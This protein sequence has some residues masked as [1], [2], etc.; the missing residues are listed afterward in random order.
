[1]KTTIFNVMV[2][3]RFVF[4]LVGFLM[5]SY[6]LLSACSASVENTPESVAAFAIKTYQKGNFGDLK[7]YATE[8]LQKQ[9]E[10]GTDDEKKFLTR[11]FEGTKVEFDKVSDYAADGSIKTVSF[12]LLKDEKSSNLKVRMVNENGKWLFD[13]MSF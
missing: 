5:I 9:L 13:G 1:M 6:C 8:D 2:H 4:G 3:K 12:T 7:E 10:K 11:M